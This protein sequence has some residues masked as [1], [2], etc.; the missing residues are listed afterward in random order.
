MAGLDHTGQGVQTHHAQVQ[1]ARGQPPLYHTSLPAAD[2]PR[3]ESSRCD[4]TR[5]RNP[6]AHD[7]L[8]TADD[9]QEEC[10]EREHV[11]GGRRLAV[12]HELRRK[13]THVS[14]E[15]QC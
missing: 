13:V 7:R 5:S 9:L 4:G 2:R 6:P 3:P 8:L 10:A 14:C 11:G 15:D 1:L 12:P